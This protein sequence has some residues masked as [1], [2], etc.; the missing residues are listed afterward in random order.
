MGEVAI[1]GCLGH[2]ALCINIVW[3]DLLGVLDFGETSKL[4][5]ICKSEINKLYL[6]SSAQSF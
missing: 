1:G 2:E 3:R 4:S 5:G 6:S